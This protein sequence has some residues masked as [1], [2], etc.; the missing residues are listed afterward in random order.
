MAAQENLELEIQNRELE[1]QNE[2]LRERN[3][4]L[5]EYNRE[6]ERRI[7]SLKFKV[8][9]R[10]ICRENKAKGVPMF[11]REQGEGCRTEGY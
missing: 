10:M 2:E 7:A 9:R 8:P 11:L 1:I 4:R 3:N 6:M 5:G